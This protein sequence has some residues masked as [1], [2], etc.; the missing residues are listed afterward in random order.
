MGDLLDHVP[1]VRD[2]LTRAQRLV[3]FTLAET[4]KEIGRDSVPTA[5][6]YGRV[7]ERLDMS[8]LQFQAILRSLGIMGDVAG[9]VRPAEGIGPGALETGGLNPRDLVG[10]EEE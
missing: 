4:A 1:D 9:T 5:M 3:L 8:E 2:G 7:V 6:L 10:D